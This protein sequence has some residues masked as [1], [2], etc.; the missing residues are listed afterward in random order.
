MK[1]RAFLLV[2]LCLFLGTIAGTAS[3]L[4]VRTIPADETVE[5]EPVTLKLKVSSRGVEEGPSFPGG[6]VEGTVGETLELEDP[7]GSSPG[8]VQ[9]LVDVP[10]G[11]YFRDVSSEELEEGSL[12]L[13]VHP[14]DPSANV[15]VRRHGVL[16]QPFPGRLMF[17]EFIVLHNDGDGLA[18][19]ENQ[20]IR[21]N[22][23][24]DL[25]RVIPGPGMAGSEDLRTVD[26]NRE[27]RRMI[28]PGESTLGF[29]YMIS[30]SED[31]YD[32]T[33]RITLPT[34]QLVFSVPKYDQLTVE[35]EGLNRRTGSEKGP[36]AE[37]WL[38]S[39]QD[40]EPGDSVK[41]SFEGL[42][43][44]APMKGKKGSKKGSGETTVE[45]P[46]DR[47]PSTFRTVSWPL[48]FGIGLSLLIFVASYG[49]VQ[50][51]LRDREVAGVNGEFLVQEIARLDQ[52]YEDGAVDEPFYKRTRRRW[53]Q[54]LEEIEDD[55]SSSV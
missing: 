14:A 5:G 40:L 11:S 2:A 42:S 54:K 53:K 10:W 32:V 45:E 4:E 28:P 6:P 29:F 48:V 39:A 17:R 36:M 22:L 23:P 52:E 34:D 3:A 44:I 9:L 21:M 50:Y 30:S 12:E 38:Y 43:D 16:A 47:R 55:E 18:G 1:Y 26:G 35:T 25:S 13:T 24:E 51:R 15:S 41:L 8:R 31:R 46:D 7:E 33:R 20:P 37:S 19:G 49:Y 27:Y